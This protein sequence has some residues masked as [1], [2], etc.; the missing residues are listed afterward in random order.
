MVRDYE[1]TGRFDLPLNPKCCKATISSGELN[2]GE[3]QQC[4]H[5]VATDEG[6]CNMHQ[7]LK[8]KEMDPDAHR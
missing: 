8:D 7:A 5:F 4:K 2:V 3:Q 6:Y 1:P